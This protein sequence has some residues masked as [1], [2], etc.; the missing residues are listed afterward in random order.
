MALAQAAVVGGSI[1]ITACV[2]MDAS[3]G[4]VTVSTAK[5]MNNRREWLYFD[6]HWIAS[7]GDS[8]DVCVVNSSFF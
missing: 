5:C 7:V 8:G 1:G 2:G 6:H 3:S 4:T